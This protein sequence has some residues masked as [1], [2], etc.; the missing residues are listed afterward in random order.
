MSVINMAEKWKVPSFVVEKTVRRRRTFSSLQLKEA[1]VA[2]A[3][4]D[5]DLKTGKI[6]LGMV[7]KII[8]SLCNKK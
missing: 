3:N 1:V 4:A 8:I 5:R 7:E 2:L 6:S